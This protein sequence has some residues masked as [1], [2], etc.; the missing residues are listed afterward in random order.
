M[1]WVVFPPNFC[2]IAQKTEKEF[3]VQVQHPQPPRF[4]PTLKA[5]FSSELCLVVLRDYTL[6]NPTSQSVS[7]MGEWGGGATQHKFES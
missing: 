3:R 1:P 5:V 6:I 4:D 7:L 2:A